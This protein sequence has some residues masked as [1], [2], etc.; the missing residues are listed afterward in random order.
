VYY[1]VGI[2]IA[3]GQDVEASEIE[4]LLSLLR[5]QFNWRCRLHHIHTLCYRV[6]KSDWN[7]QNYL[8]VQRQMVEGEYARNSEWLINRPS[9]S[10]KETIP[11]IHFQISNHPPG[12]SPNEWHTILLSSKSSLKAEVPNKLTLHRLKDW[13]EM[14]ELKRASN[15]NFSLS[16]SV[17]D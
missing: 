5:H 13:L 4:P 8:A 9:S 6:R 14:I 7:Y 2:G 10:L 15:V 12:L 1:F 11:L 17:K 16:H 3:I